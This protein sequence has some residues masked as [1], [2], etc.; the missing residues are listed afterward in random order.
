[1]SKKKLRLIFNKI[2]Q[3]FPSLMGK[4]FDRN[5]NI[6]KK[7]IPFKV[8]KY[9]SGSKC[10]DWIIPKSWDCFNAYIKCGGK[11]IINTENN[12]LHVVSH[13]YPVKKFIKG[14]D[15]KK[16]LFFSKDFP[17]SIPYVTS[18]YKKNWG[19]SLSY[20]DYKKISNKKIYFV[21]INS[22]L[23]KSDLKLGHLLLKGKSN[24]EILL[25]TY[26][27]HTGTANHECGGPL[28]MVNLYKKLKKIKLKYSIRLLLIPEN[29]GSAAYL[30]S[31]GNYLKKNVIAGY[32]MHF[33]GYGSIFNFKKSKE[34]NSLTNYGSLEFLKLKKKKFK[35]QNYVAD[36]SDERQFCSPFFNLPIG[37]ISR[38]IYPSFKAY[39]NSLDNEKKINFT[40]LNDSSKFYFE[41][42]KYLN[43]VNFYKSIVQKGTFFFTKRNLKIYPT[44]MQ[45]SAKKTKSKKLKDILNI[46][47]YLDG[48]TSDL[49]VRNKL[50]LNKKEFSNY[51]NFLLKKKLISKII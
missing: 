47:N 6:L 21:N 11:I 18:Y 29:I 3:T 43:N 31:H 44:N 35:L 48:H 20:K 16:H 7:Y 33:L 30:S 42:I 10:L 22:K 17:N 14:K 8:L 9:K 25:S 24:K 19:F 51:I 1:M 37:S 46:I 40:T 50:N 23:K 39:H 32:V 15:L 34:D 2:Y 36:G 26:L 41:L 5:L 13:S 27:C 4:D 38:E 49:V 12:K 28:A 45:W